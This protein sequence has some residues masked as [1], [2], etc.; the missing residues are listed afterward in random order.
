MS[1]YITNT[2]LI[3]LIIVGAKVKAQDPGT[4]ID[5]RIW[6]SGKLVQGNELEEYKATLGIFNKNQSGKEKPIQ[7]ERLT[8][9]FHSFEWNP[10]FGEI[11]ELNI[12]HSSEK[13]IIHFKVN[14]DTLENK[15]IANIFFNLDIPFQSGYFE[16]TD[17][18]NLTGGVEFNIKKE[19]Q[20]ISLTADKRKL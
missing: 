16:L 13:M 19:Q 12:S 15:M 20:W 11:Y 18:T 5:I 3:L 17:F 14:V 9:H 7:F 1:K 6:K 4:V 2:V 8:E 10:Y